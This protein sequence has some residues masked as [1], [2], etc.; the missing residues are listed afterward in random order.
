MDK[1]EVTNAHYKKFVR[2]T[3]GQRDPED[4]NFKPWQDKNFN[5]DNQPVI[6]VSWEDAKAYVE[7]A[8]KRLPTEAEWE[9]SARGGSV[10][11][12]Y[13]WGDEWPPPKGAGNFAGG[14]FKKIFPDR[15]IINGYDDGYAYTSPVGSFNPNGYGLYDMAGNVWEWC[16]D[17]YYVKYYADS[18]RE[19]PKGPSFGSSRV[20]RGASW[21]YHHPAV[22]RVSYRDSY[23]TSYCG[24]IVG[25]RCAG[26]SVTP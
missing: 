7:W 14:T 2:A 22:I 16:A 17:W 11:K 23:G 21:D 20:L 8:E 4:G 6:C 5:G 1:Y 9:K 26:L 12:N 25:F 18:P 19:N 15:T 3:T 10:G 24:D 13:V